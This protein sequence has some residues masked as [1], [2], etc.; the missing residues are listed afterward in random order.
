MAAMHAEH[1]HGADAHVTFEPPNFLIPTT[2]EIEWH[3]VADGTDACLAEG[4][5]LFAKLAKLGR[6]T[7]PNEERRLNGP[8]A[9]VA[10]EPQSFD[11]ERGRGRGRDR[12]RGRG[13]DS[14]KGR[15]KGKDG[16]GAPEAPG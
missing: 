7:W 16:D 10:Q 12:G 8:H 11:Q 5:P 2:S 6:T 15:G 3:F 13:R 14:T 9:R 1:A 4:G